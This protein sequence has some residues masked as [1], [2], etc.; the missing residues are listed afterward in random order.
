MSLFDALIFIVCF[1]TKP[2]TIKPAEHRYLDDLAKLDINNMKCIRKLY[3]ETNSRNMAI[4]RN[5]TYSKG[6][7]RLQ[8]KKLL[9]VIT[10]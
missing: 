7:S 8:E 4:E 1:A 3:C 5:G 2:I 10:N 6:I 9:L